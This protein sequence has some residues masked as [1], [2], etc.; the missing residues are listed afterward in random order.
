MGSSCS[1]ATFLQTQDQASSCGKRY[2][3][4]F[5]I[6]MTLLSIVGAVFIWN[7]HS[8]DS[9]DVDDD[10]IAKRKRR[11]TFMLAGL[12]VLTLL[13]WLAIPLGSMM[14]NYRWKSYNNDINGYM[15]AGFSRQ[16]AI[17]KVQGLYQTNQQTDAIIGAAAMLAGNH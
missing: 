12:G 14:M 3:L 7:S 8:I 9:I 10:T 17:S 4:I 1:T 16:K 5:A 15:K 6:I 2:G 13:F 11:K